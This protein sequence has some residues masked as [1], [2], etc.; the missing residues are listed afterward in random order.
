MDYKDKTREYYERRGSSFGG[1]KPEYNQFVS[2]FLRED[3]GLFLLNLKGT[4]VL[5]LGCGPGR[6]ALFFKGEGLTP[7]CVD[8]SSAMARDCKN[9]GLISCVMDLENLGFMDE[10]FD[11]VWAYT[12]LHNIPKRNA[13]DALKGISR[14]LKKNGQFFVGVKEG[15]YEGYVPASNMLVPDECRFIAHYTEEELTGLLAS[16]FTVTHSCKTQP[17]EHSY[18]LNF[19]CEKK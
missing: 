13:A 3:V 19:L 1:D 6:D 17:D 5:D 12:S 9:K 16:C 7:I 18:Y 4:R 10:A 15:D 14:V 8:I 2:R 11:G